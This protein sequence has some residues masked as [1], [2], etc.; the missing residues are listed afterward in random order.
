MSDHPITSKLFAQSPGAAQDANAR[1]VYVEFSGGFVG[2]HVRHRVSSKG[3]TVAAMVR[4]PRAGVNSDSVINSLSGFV[5]A[6]IKIEV[7][8]DKPSV[9]IVAACLLAGA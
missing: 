2:G 8:G 3:K 4:R 9:E 6:V 5:V 7:V 1:W